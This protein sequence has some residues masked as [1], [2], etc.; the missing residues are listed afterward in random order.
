MESRIESIDVLKGIGILL[1]VYGHVCADTELTHFIYSFHMPL[2]FIVSGFLFNTSKYD[3]LKSLVVRRLKT[4]ICPY[5][6]F[7]FFGIALVS[8]NAVI[9][10]ESIGTYM[11]TLLKS[12]YSVIWA[13]Y[14]IH[15]FGLFNV[16]MWFVPCLFLIEVLYYLIDKMCEKINGSFGAYTKYFVIAVLV[17]AG[18]FM[19]SSLTNINF[20]FLPCNFSSA[21]F[22]LGFY[23]IG[24]ILPPP[25]NYVFVQAGGRNRLGCYLLR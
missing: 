5:I 19:E 21:C 17:F 18:W 25:K 9:T 12:L 8:L 16:P 11:D 1:V 3:T 7:C 20:S 15:Y 22:S 2:F 13:P 6:L 10:H 14:S 23:A 24:N 4:L